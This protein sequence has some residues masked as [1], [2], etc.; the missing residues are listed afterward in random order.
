MTHF[1]GD[2]VPPPHMFG[3]AYALV[4]HNYSSSPL[5]HSLA[6]IQKDVRN[7]FFYRCRFNFSDSVKVSFGN[8]MATSILLHFYNVQHIVNLHHSYDN[9]NNVT[10]HTDNDVSSVNLITDNYRI[11]R[12]ATKLKP[13]PIEEKMAIKLIRITI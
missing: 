8:I 10:I 6:R 2:H 12:T 7:I 1:P 4:P 13:Q 3:A 5:K 9:I 11:L